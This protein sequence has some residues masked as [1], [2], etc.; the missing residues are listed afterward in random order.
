MIPIGRKGIS[1][2]WITPDGL[3]QVQGWARDGLTDEQIAGNIGISAQTYYE[4]QKRFPEFREALKKGKA[5]VDIQVENALLKRALGY[6]YEET[7]T[8]I[9]Q[10]ADGREIKHVRRIRKHMP[11]EV[12]AIVFWLKNRRPG[13]WRDKVEQAPEASNELLMSLLALERQAKQ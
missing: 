2:E 9:Q 1:G 11:P 12:G 8:E 10:G 6:D 5:P 13:K 4:W 7:V 3:L